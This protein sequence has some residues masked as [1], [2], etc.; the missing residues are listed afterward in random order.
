MNPAPHIGVS[1]ITGTECTP[2]APDNENLFLSETRTP[3]EALQ[4]A[5]RIKKEMSG[6]LKADHRLWNC[7]KHRQTRELVRGLEQIA[8]RHVSRET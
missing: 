5:R 1:I 7:P 3:A 4:V 2:P 6:E 8:L